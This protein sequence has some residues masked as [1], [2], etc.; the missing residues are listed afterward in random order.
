[1]IA[2]VT[3]DDRRRLMFHNG[4]SWISLCA[5]HDD[6]S[7]PCERSDGQLVRENAQLNSIS[8]EVCLHAC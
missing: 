2:K 8:V 6:M 1:M 3:G 5:A 7:G 4:P